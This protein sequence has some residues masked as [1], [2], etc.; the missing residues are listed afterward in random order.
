MGLLKGKSGDELEFEPFPGNPENIERLKPTITQS[1]EA[2]YKGILGGKLM[3]N[4]NA[5][6]TKV[7]DF[8]G[9][10]S[11][12]TP[13]VFFNDST[14]FA[15]LFP[16]FQ[17]NYDNSTNQLLKSFLLALDDPELG[18][19]GNGNGTPADE[20]AEIYASNASKIPFGT[21]TPEEAYDPNAIIA[22]FRNFGNVEFWG[23]ELSFNYF[24]NR[25]W[26]FSGSYAHV[27]RDAFPKSESQSKTIYLNAPKNKIGLGVQYSRPESGLISELRYRWVDS[28]PMQS[29]YETDIIA[30]YSLVD[31]NLAYDILPHTNLALS[32]TN[33]LNTKHRQVINAPEIGRLAIMRLSYSF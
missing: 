7:K 19:G 22:T 26:T 23:A 10:L 29:V 11:I 21:A 33:L 20:L 9:P 4:V 18:L 1:Y 28:F 5:Y 30:S 27:S 24:L 3:L 25:N 32:I 16:A 2:G 13:N 14:L 17:N 8:I 31:L 6:Y 12:E 15:S